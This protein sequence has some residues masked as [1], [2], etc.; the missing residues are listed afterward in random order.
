MHDS[1]YTRVMPLSKDL[2]DILVCPES[3]QP[4]IYFESEGFLLCPASRRKY[5]IDDGIPVMLVEESEALAPGA[6]D[7]LVAQ[8]REHGLG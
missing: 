2:L 4:L 1:D 8:A 7:A 3:K 5:R 6:V